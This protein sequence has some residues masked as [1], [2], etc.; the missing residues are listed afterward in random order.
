MRITW[1]GACAAVLFAPIAF[2]VA[3]GTASSAEGANPVPVVYLGLSD[4][5]YHTAVKTQTWDELVGSVKP[6]DWRDTGHRCQQSCHPRGSVNV[7]RVECADTGKVQNYSLFWEHEGS[8][9][10]DSLLLNWG[11]GRAW[12]LTRERWEQVGNTIPIWILSETAGNLGLPIEKLELLWVRD[13]PVKLQNGKTVTVKQ[14][15]GSAVFAKPATGDIDLCVWLVPGRNGLD[16]IVGH[17][18]D[19]CDFMGNE[20]RDATWVRYPW[21]LDGTLPSTSAGAEPGA[22]Q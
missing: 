14:V 1:A 22:A 9:P 4:F 5:D 16:Q 21:A 15:T 7:C 3:F 2:G 20:A 10:S 12:E 19:A 17:A 8:A 13:V 18:T 6:M 11:D